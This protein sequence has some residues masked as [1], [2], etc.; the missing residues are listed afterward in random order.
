M[1]IDSI[2]ECSGLSLDLLQSF[3]YKSKLGKS[4]KRSLGHFDKEA[5]F[6]ELFDYADW[7]DSLDIVSLVSLDFR[8]KAYESIVGKYERYYPNNPVLKIFND[9]LGFRTFCDNY[10]EILSAESE[11]LRMVD[12]S[13]GKANDD[14]YRGVHVYYQYDNF[15]YP[16]EIQFNTLFDRQINNWLHD[17]LY[18]KEYPLEYGKEL[19]CQYEKGMIRNENEFKEVL[20]NDLLSG[21][22]QK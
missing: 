4:L 14:G 19:R 20:F 5:L 13:E 11:I 1:S 18:K 7:L 6:N 17:Y 15:H 10:D 9:I 8:I 12:M 3:S 22:E 16:I 21:K 2:L